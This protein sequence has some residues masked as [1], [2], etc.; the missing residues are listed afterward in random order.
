MVWGG[1]WTAGPLLAQ[2]QPL[3]TLGSVFEE[4]GWFPSHEELD[5]P[6]P[7]EPI[8]PF[9]PQSACP[10]NSE[11]DPTELSLLP[12][13]EQ[14][15]RGTSDSA[16]TVGSLFPDSQ[17][18]SPECYFGPELAFAEPPEDWGWSQLPPP[19]L[20]EEELRPLRRLR[21]RWRV[22][23]QSR[24]LLQNIREDHL[25]FYSWPT[26][27]DLGLGLA[28]AAVFANTS[29]DEKFQD[30]Y[31][32]DV[33]SEGLDNLSSF[34]KPWGE[35]AIFV[36]SYAAFGVL[37]IL[38]SQRPVLGVV[39]RFGQQVSRA[40]LVG[41]PPLLF[42]QALSG[43]ARPV[44]P[45]GSQWRP[46]Q[47]INGLSGH[48][49]IGAVPFLI[50]AQ[51]TDRP[52]LQAALYVGSAF[53]AWSRLNDD[54]HYLSQVCLGWWVAFLACRAVYQTETGERPWT[55]VPIAGGNHVGLALV[56]TR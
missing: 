55:L 52:V 56:W 16:A 19:P 3:S 14:K 53:P 12:S 2:T 29:L 46:F 20:L 37:G 34:W 9:S 25:H 54:S 23:A 47:D 18:A 35:G 32:E 4:T 8:W 11:P 51:W 30:W 27:R 50:A 13:V 17:P 5:S 24:L 28:L 49:F 40:Y 6:R 1:L 41:A 36:P 21:Y 33:R 10:D 43:G 44:D 15:L 38:A 22:R 7:G 39:G 26:F 42:L 45:E 48:A 31:R